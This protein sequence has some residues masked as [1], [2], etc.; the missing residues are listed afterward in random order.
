M[1]AFQHEVDILELR[2]RSATKKKTEVRQGE[3][4]EY[5]IHLLE[6]D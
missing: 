6:P 4:L 5:T 1:I 2:T 3:I